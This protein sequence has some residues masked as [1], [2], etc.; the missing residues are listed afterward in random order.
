GEILA[1]T[2][3]LE[4]GDIGRFEKVGNY[5]SYC[6]CVDSWKTSNRKKKGEGNRKNGNKHL[7]WAYVEAAN[8]AGR[9]HVLAQQF[10]QRKS[11]GRNPIL[12]T[13]ALSNKICRASFYMMRDGV[14]F[15]G[16]RLF[17]RPEGCGGKPRKGIGSNPFA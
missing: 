15:D 16:K 11:G 9:F 10:H 6:R 1:M 13:K 14:P 4:V 5:S 7:G 12:A 3:M 2:I 17:A 8:F